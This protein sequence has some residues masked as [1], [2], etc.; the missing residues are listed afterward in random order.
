MQ[1]ELVIVPG[2]VNTR[3]F[4]FSNDSD[5]IGLIESYQ[6]VT[7]LEGELMV[8]VIK[9]RYSHR[10]RNIQIVQDHREFISRAVVNLSSSHP[11][12]MISVGAAKTW[13]AIAS[14]GQVI[15]VEEVPLG[16]GTGL[17]ELFN[18]VTLSDWGRWFPFNEMDYTEASN[19]LGMKS[20]YPAIVPPSE[21]QR[22]IELI[23][24]RE[25]LYQI[26]YLVGSYIDKLQSRMLEMVLP[27]VVLC[28]AVFT[29]QPN[30]GQSLLAALDGLGPRGVWQV[31]VDS[32]NILPALGA[33][34]GQST[35]IVMS[36]L[37]FIN[38]GSV[39]IL[40]HEYQKAKTLGRLSFDLGLD[41]K[42]EVEIKAGDMVRVPYD[43]QSVGKVL[44]DVD[45]DVR[46]SSQD[47]SKLT[48]GE[49]GIIID[50]RRRPLERAYSKH[51][52]EAVT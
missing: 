3:A 24:A 34:P 43:A 29:D 25:I 38:L 35:K 23:T 27:R 20:L 19:Y 45:A 52:V 5:N 15:K 6:L 14:F 47:E 49:L 46:I 18:R 51:W 17:S 28:G 50:A 10:Y 39:I 26:R 30:F 7:S 42:Q 48:G 36:R 40:E 44:F 9:Q 41:S 11:V 31:W 37:G 13:V 22:Q 4:L 33:F 2:S 32:Q 12:V 16:L 1:A 8:S 21:K